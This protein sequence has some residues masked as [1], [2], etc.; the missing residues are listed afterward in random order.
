MYEN[1]ACEMR[2]HA[3]KLMKRS[4]LMTK[5]EAGQYLSECAD[6]IYSLNKDFRDCRNELC[7]LCGKYKEKYK[8]ACTGCRWA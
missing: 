5:K 2:E 8:G 4:P 3:G 6:A 1:L 7:L